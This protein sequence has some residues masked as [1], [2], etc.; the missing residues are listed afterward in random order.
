MAIPATRA[1]QQCERMSTKLL[2]LEKAAFVLLFVFAL[3]AEDRKQTVSYSSTRQFAFPPPGIYSRTGS[4]NLKRVT[5]I[6]LAITLSMFPDMPRNE[7]VKFLGAVLSSCR[8]R[9]PRYNRK[10]VDTRCFGDS[11]TPYR[12]L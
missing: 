10:G 6:K 12:R 4:T 3:T 5:P 2:R 1:K 8:V 11:E 7:H 9:P